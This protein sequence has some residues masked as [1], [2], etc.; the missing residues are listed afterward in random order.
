MSKYIFLLSIL[1][2]V[3]SCGPNKGGFATDPRSFKNTNSIFEPYINLYIEN[4]RS[5]LY[6]DIPVQFG[7]LDGLTIGLC[8]RWS[9]GYRQIEIDKEYWD[10]A[11]ERYRLSLIAHEFGHCD[12]LKDHSPSIDSIMYYQNWGSLN[13]DELFNRKVISNKLA[14]TQQDSLDHHDG[15]VH[16]IEVE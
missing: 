4:K 7:E 14:F 12:L 2:L 3:I 10:S 6:Y 11:S 8:T 9:N 13:F 15:C 16:D 5:G 1:Q